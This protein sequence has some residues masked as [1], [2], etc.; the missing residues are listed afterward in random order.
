MTDTT[1][2]L[3]NQTR[4][5]AAKF[6]G[7]SKL[8]DALGHKSRST[9]QRWDA[10]GWIRPVYYRDILEAAEKH[11]IPLEHSDFHTID[12]QVFPRKAA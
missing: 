7:K 9:V 2:F 10:A 1:G 8:A 6:G 5:I 12:P 3:I 4:V 11:G